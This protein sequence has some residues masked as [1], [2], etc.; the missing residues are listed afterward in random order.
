MSALGGELPFRPTEIA[1]AHLAER[2]GM[3]VSYIRKLRKERPDL[4]DA[5]VNGWL[6]GEGVG[7]EAGPDGEWAGYLSQ[8]GQFDTRSFLVRTFSDP[9]G[10]EGIAEAVLSDRFGIYDNLDMLM[11]AL[12][13]IK[14]SGAECDV[15]SCDLSERA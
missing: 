14:A 6:L 12:A 13:G 5:N 2:I 9:D 8:V 4:Y 3:P 11:A 7:Y 15:V 10:G 1:D